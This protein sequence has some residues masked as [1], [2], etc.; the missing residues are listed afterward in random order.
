MLTGGGNTKRRG[1][2]KLVEATGLSQKEICARFDVSPEAFSRWLTGTVQPQHP[3]MLRLALQMLV[4]ERYAREDAAARKQVKTNKLVGD[5]VGY[6]KSHISP[7]LKD[8]RASWSQAW[9]YH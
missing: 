5:A 4:V 3:G 2:R 1:L 7:S 9:K 8:K 6:G